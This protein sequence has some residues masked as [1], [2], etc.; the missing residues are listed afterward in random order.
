MEC[1]AEYDRAMESR[2]VQVESITVACS[3]GQRFSA[4][5]VVQIRADQIRSDQS[6]A[7]Q[8]SATQ[9]RPKQSTAQQS[10]R[11]SRLSAVESFRMLCF[12]PAQGPPYVYSLNS[13]ANCIAPQQINPKMSAF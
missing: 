6:R 11:Q 2:E 13:V 9:I 8:Y 1:S 10:Q 5:Q 3:A 12:V 4:K 7:E